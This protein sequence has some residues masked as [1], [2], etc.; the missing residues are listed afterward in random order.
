MSWRLVVLG[1]ALLAALVAA[2]LESRWQ[3]EAFVVL[4]IVGA[5]VVQLLLGGGGSADESVRRRILAPGS[6]C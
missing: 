5:R 6:S 1:V 2:S 3:A 4:F